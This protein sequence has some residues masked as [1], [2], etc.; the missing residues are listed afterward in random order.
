MEALRRQDTSQQLRQVR[1]REGEAR[2]AAAEAEERV[3]QLEQQ[4]A[5]VRG[6]T[7]GPYS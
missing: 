6:L 7:S 3:R 5:E 4:L 1:E 2:R